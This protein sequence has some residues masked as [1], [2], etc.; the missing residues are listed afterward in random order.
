M[1]I[2]RSL[3]AR[4]R[5]LRRLGAVEDELAAELQDHLEREVERQRAAGVPEDEARRRALWRVGSMRPSRRR[6]VTSAVAGGCWMP[7]AMRASA[8]GASA[9]HQASR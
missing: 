1:S 5:I 3:A 4:A 9:G 2:L 8:C 6:F 7:S